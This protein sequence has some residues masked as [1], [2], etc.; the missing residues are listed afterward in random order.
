[1]FG[2]GGVAGRWASIETTTIKS[3]SALSAAQ[4]ARTEDMPQE[5]NRAFLSVVTFYTLAKTLKRFGL[6]GFYLGRLDH[7]K[8]T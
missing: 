3:L 2:A 7:E 4:E 5:S 8:P 6:H 1:M